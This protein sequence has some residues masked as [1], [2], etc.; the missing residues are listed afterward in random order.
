MDTHQHDLA[1]VCT[2]APA[3]PAPPTCHLPLYTLRRA[4]MLAQIDRITAQR[5][6]RGYTMRYGGQSFRVPGV[7]GQP[8]DPVGRERRL[9]FTQMLTLRLIR[10]LRLAGISLYVI[11]RVA[12]LAAF[13]F[14]GATPLVTHRFRTE[15]A[16]LFLLRED[17]CHDF[18][19]PDLP[20]RSQDAEEVWVWRRVFADFVEPGLFRHIDW[21]AD[22][23][24]RWWPMGHAGSIVIDPAILSGAAHVGGTG[25]ATARIA[26]YVRNAGGDARALAAA[27]TRHGLSLEQ[28]RAADRFEAVWF[29]TR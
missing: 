19:D 22:G 26:A 15:G 8:G 16:I 29:R 6:D 12:Q 1:T 18:D 17:A 28:A 20:P 23:A 2:A 14:G 27:A 7:I 25:I 11:R 10:C 21:A 5:W 9:S 24:R 13:E 4:A 3:Q